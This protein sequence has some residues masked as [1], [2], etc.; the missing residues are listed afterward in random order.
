[1]G[2]RAKGSVV[3]IC[4]GRA[5]EGLSLSVVGDS[6]MP[7]RLYL[8]LSVLAAR[9][10]QG[11][12]VIR[13]E[14]KGIACRTERHCTLP[15]RICSESPPGTRGVDHNSSDS[16]VSYPAVDAVGRRI[17]SSEAH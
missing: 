14:R 12:S 2:Y 5:K 8:S 9:S 4:P 6:T 15:A 10:A 16:I 3:S 13:P 1:M 17:A 11:S 7:D